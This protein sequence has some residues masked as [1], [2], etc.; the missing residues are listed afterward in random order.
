MEIKESVLHILRNHDDI[1]SSREIIERL[2]DGMAS[3]MAPPTLRKIINQL[4]CEGYPII[5]KHRGYKFSK[6]DEEIREW[7]SAMD[8]R[9]K[10]MVQARD[11]VLKSKQSIS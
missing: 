6:S 5:S 11:G 3:F 4:R 10:K 8:R 7:S 2:G 9:I 1:I